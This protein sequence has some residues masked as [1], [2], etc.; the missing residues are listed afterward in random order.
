M[1]MHGHRVIF[2]DIFAK[3]NLILSDANNDTVR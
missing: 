3:I 2:V 1:R